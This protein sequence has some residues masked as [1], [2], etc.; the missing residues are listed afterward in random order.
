MNKKGVIIGVIVVAI[1]IGIAASFSSS[2]SETVNRLK[3][4]T[5]NY[6]KSFV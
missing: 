6:E 3:K 1:A 2:P 4:L 5:P